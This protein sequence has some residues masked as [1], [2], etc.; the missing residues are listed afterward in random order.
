MGSPRAKL[1]RPFASDRSVGFRDYTS[2]FGRGGG[3]VEVV[4]SRI[5][6]S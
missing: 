3:E 1:V 2:C 6:S 5:V 4:V